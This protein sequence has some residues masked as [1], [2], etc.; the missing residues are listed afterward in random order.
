MGEDREEDLERLL[1]LVP[2]FRDLDRVSLARLAGALEPLEVPQGTLVTREGASAQ[3]LYLLE[4][5]AV[6][7]S[8]HSLSGNIEVGS[9][10]A[11]GS[12]G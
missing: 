11:P 6:T 2:Y 7:A 9:I 12:F 1:R 5:G 8:V 3:E 10:T 4:T